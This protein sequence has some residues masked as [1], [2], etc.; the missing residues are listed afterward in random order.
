MPKRKPIR[1]ASG[2]FQYPYTFL[3]K[4]NQKKSLEGKYKEKQKIAIDGTE[5]TVR[6]TDQKNLR[7]KLLSTPLEIQKS[8]EKNVSPKKHTE[9]TRWKVHES[10]GRS[11]ETGRRRSNLRVQTKGPE[12]GI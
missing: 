5:H 2:N 9:R 10:I 11:E 1:P 3:E 12:G 6:T 7:R 4:R 8:P